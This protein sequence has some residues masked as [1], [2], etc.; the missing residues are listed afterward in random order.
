MNEGSMKKNSANDIRPEYDFS[1]M[2]GG[3]RGKY[4]ARYRAGTNLVLLDPE[5]AK[6][7]PTDAAVNQTLRALLDIANEVRLPGQ[8][9]RAGS[10]RRR[11][12]TPA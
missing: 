10:R 8:A 5:V 6:A 7:F 2:K 4:S 1:S 12:S 9:R 11:R 3:V